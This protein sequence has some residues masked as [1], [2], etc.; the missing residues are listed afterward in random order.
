MKVLLIYDCVHPESLGGIE[1]RNYCLSRALADR[2]HEVTI[3]GWLAGPGGTQNGVTILPMKFRRL[4]HVGDG[5]RS[6]IASLKF[7]AAAAC[8]DVAPYDVVETANIPYA[9]IIP[10]ALR[11]ALAGK[12]LVVTWHEFFGSY[13]RQYQGRASGLAYQIVEWLTA[14]IG[15]LN[16]ASPLTARR[17]Q[18]VRR[19]R[20][21]ATLPLA[22]CGVSL[23]DV[24][25]AW[26]LPALSAPPL[27]F[28]GRLIPEKRVDLLLQAVALMPEAATGGDSILLGIC[29]DGPDR[30]R[31]MALAESLGIANRVTFFGRLPENVDMWRLLATTRVA[32][33]PS[34]REGF[35]LFP[36]EAISLGRPVVTCDSPESA[37]SDIVRDGIEGFCTKA[38]PACL[39]AAMTRLLNDAPLWQRMSEA[40]LL[41]APLYDWPSV[42]E[43][44]EKFLGGLFARPN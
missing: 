21:G 13:W 7:A 9:H 32:V 15:H 33:Q 27:L 29:G 25:A 35:G 3:A 42:A 12:P 31:L 39:A 11:C 34:V 24:R 18:D 14:Q 28:G 23:K 26:D 8:L 6:T 4:I 30:P 5:R 41:R 10:L 36:L 16:A 38:E 22:A 43:R 1:Y 44:F 20:A 19:G 40:A 37:V 17:M 2:G